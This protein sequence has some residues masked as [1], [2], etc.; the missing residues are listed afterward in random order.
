MCLWNI[1]A[2][3]APPAPSRLPDVASSCEVSG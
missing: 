1:E 3:S 2:N